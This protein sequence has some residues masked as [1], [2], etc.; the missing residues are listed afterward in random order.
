MSP[1]TSSL[2]Q[3]E[4]DL[5]RI[6]AFL[7]HLPHKPRLV[8]FEEKIQLPAVRATVRVW[9]QNN[10]IVG[11]AYVDPFN[12]LW[13]ETDLN[14]AHEL[15]QLVFDWGVDCIRKRNAETGEQTT[16]DFSCDANDPERLAFTERFGFDREEVRTLYYSRPLDDTLITYP[17]PHGFSIRAALG[18]SEVDAL[19]ALHRAAFGTENMT[20]EERLAIMRAPGYIPELDLVAV[21]PDGGLA[22]FCICGFDE[23]DPRAGYTDPIGVH[24]LYQKIGLGKAIVSAGLRNLQLRGA[25][26]ARLGTSSQNNA[27]QKLAERMGFICEAEKFWFSKKI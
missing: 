16:L 17:L 19:V 1:I 3:N 15:E 25:R 13:F 23:N 18:E 7:A 24:P 20:A 22:A 27:M 4:A 14:F 2:L 11:M 8:D 26:I 9:E 12:N 21:A 5:N 6:R 10:E